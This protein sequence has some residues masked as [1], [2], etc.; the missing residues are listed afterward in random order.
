VYLKIGLSGRGKIL[1]VIH[2]PYTAAEVAAAQTRSL[3]CGMRP[4]EKRV[5]I[6]VSFSDESGVADPTG[7]FL[8]SGY[9]ADE[10]NWP[11]VAAAW[12]ERVLDGPPKIPY[13]H[14]KEIR[15][16]EWRAEHGITYN[17]AEDRISEAVRVLYSTGSMSAVASVIKRQDIQELFHARYKRK[18]NVPT[19]LD[20]P[21]Y[22][23]FVAYASFMLAEVYRRYPE[24]ER[25]NFIVSKKHIVTQR[26]QEFYEVMKKYFQQ[27]HPEL[28]P[29]F[30]DLLPGDMEIQLPLQAADVLCW[31]IQKSYAKTF[32]RV[33]E[34]RIAL[35]C[36]DRDGETHEWERSEL[37]TMANNLKK[38][39]MP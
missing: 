7:E 29:L 17:Q 25:V 5:A 21:D 23:C 16:P 9:V 8:V 37:E 4:K 39:G 24:A 15:R 32:D 11:Y 2:L 22:F 27:N 34:G 20:E 36:N 12:Q 1:Q 28:F 10:K 18:K 31:H 26:L 33:E 35:L 6:F 3:F 14:M 13:F 38:L 30:G 19:G